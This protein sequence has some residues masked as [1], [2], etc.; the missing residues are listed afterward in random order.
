MTTRVFHDL[1]DPTMIFLVA[2]H[3]VTSMTCRGGGNEQKIVRGDREVSPW[4][5]NMNFAQVH[6]DLEHREEKGHLLDSTLLT[7]KMF[8]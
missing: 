1:L 5:G 6:R 2:E 7:Y 3:K 4:V 8:P